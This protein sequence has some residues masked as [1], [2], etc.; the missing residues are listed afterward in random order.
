MPSKRQFVEH[1]DGCLEIIPKTHHLIAPWQPDGATPTMLSIPTSNSQI[2][3][4]ADTEISPDN[5]NNTNNFP[6]SNQGAIDTFPQN[7]RNKGLVLA[8]SGASKQTGKSKLRCHLCMDEKT[9]SRNEAMA[10][11]MRT[12]HLGHSSSNQLTPSPESQYIDLTCGDGDEARLPIP[13]PAP[14]SLC[15]QNPPLHEETMR[16][17]VDAV[18]FRIDTQN[19][20]TSN[21]YT[22]EIISSDSSDYGDYESIFATLVAPFRE[23]HLC[24]EQAALVNLIMSGR[25]VFY[26][27]SAGCG[28][29]TVLKN[30]V[31][32]LKE[33]GKKVDIIA[34]TGRAALDVNGTTFWTYAGWTPDSMKIPIKKL[35]SN[36]LFQKY[37]CKRLRETDTLVIDEI[38]MMENHHLERLN[39]IM[40][41]AR[42]NNTAFGGTQVVITGDFFQ[43]PPVKPF[44]Y[45][46]ECGR[47]LIPRTR[48]DQ[49]FYSCFEHG[50]FEDDDKYAFSS[51][52]WK[53][54]NFEHVDLKYIHRQSNQEFITILQKY[55]FS[56]PRS[57][58]D[59]DLLLN[60]ECET[61]D[62]VRLF[63]TR[64]EVKKVNEREFARLNGPTFT[65]KSTDDF[66]WNRDH[67]NLHFK[68]ERDELNSLLALK[69]SRFEA[70]VE[71]RQGMLVVLLV[72]LDIKC[73]LVNGSQG[74]VVDFEEHNPNNMPKQMGDHAGRKEDLIGDFIGRAAEKK[75]PVVRFHNGV[76]RAIYAECSVNELGDTVPYSLLSRAQIPLLAAWAMTVHK[77][78]GM[79]LSRVVVDLTK[80]F[81]KGQEY[82]ALSRAR[83][84]EGLKVEGL[85]DCNGGGNKQVQKFWKEKFGI[86]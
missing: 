10:R 86:E 25:N 69:D 29:S 60:H 64:D 74:V 61:T 5:T 13:A 53:E 16:V 46:I 68:G 63:P 82:V 73:G 44:Q 79:T 81:E 35:Q 70:S 3:C 39:Q 23:P 65:F 77:S 20:Q 37:V 78:Q 33:A 72:N 84:L 12:M 18:P 21:Q 71:F 54:A 42:M 52:A 1:P 24:E 8:L 51:K 27:G 28:K 14:P 19:L 4:A 2:Y 40:K 66:D 50:E 55:R 7:V 22:A 45:C 75:W 31:K 43:L 80:S 36:A 47:H 57:E 83:G 59:K 76:Q 26:T 34:P 67:P 15:Q 11:H 38:S 9:F 62:A 49:G 32:R 48:K 30:F 41:S 56:K 17:S 6:T 58:A 85:G